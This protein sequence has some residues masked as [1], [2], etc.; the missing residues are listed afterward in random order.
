MK[1]FRLLLSTTCVIICIFAPTIIKAD[2]LRFTTID[3]CPFTCDPLK[4]NGKEGFMTDV[5]RATFEEA[6]YSI[7][8]KM[9]PYARAVAAVNSGE[10]DGIV[11]VGKNYAPNLVYPDIPTESQPMSFFVKNETSWKYSGVE[12]LSEVVVGIVKGYDYADVDLNRHFEEQ[13][14]SEKIVMLHGVNTTERGLRMLQTKRVDTYIDGEYSV[15]YVLEKLG[16]SDTIIVVG[17]AANRF[18]DFTG[19]NPHNPKSADYAKLLSNKIR[20]MKK[21]GELNKILSRYGI[22]S[23]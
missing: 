8:I 14:D 23:E 17:Y 11:V 19:F 6:G 1:Y 5:L 16:L 15:L 7:E 9:F 4:E 21:T 2:S 3:Y 22:V 20:E 18:E 13:S 10:Y 12:S